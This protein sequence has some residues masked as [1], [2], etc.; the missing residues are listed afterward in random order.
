MDLVTFT[1][2]DFPM[3]MPPL[4]YGTAVFKDYKRVN[5]INLPHSHM[6]QINGP[7]KETKY[8]HH[9]MID[10]IEFDTFYKADLQSINPS[11]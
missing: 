11:K 8:A 4:M 9:F 6:F 7:S 3:M 1:F 2:R 5:G 10:K